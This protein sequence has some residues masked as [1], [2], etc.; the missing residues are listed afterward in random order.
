[1]RK[2][3][4]ALF[5][6]VSTGMIASPVNAQSVSAV[7]GWVGL[8]NTPVGA[9]TPVVTG[10]TAASSPGTGAQIRVSNWQPN[11]SDDNTTSLGLGLVVNQGRA[12]TVFEVGYITRTGCDECGG[13]MGG[14]DMQLD[15]AQSSVANG[16]S[17]FMVALNP[18]VGVGVPEKG[19]SSVVTGG[20]SLPVS[21]S[22]NA[23]ANLRMVPFVSP[24]VSYSRFNGGGSSQT[25]S[26]AMV[27]G[28]L[29]V[30]SQRSAMLFTASA[31]KVF[32]E[33]SPMIYGLGLVFAR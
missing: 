32:I 20:L 25:G 26:R 21:A 7:A 33:D 14:I 18:A 13:Y 28:G 24:G 2:I 11:N 27:S 23:G 29:S 16:A 3:A 31:R 22:V 6:I 30:G 17:S 5:S 9:L 12:R 10:R 8:I 15:L 1:M 4:F 19:G